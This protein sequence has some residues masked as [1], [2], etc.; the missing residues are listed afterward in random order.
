MSRTRH[1]FD[2]FRIIAP[3]VL[4]MS[5]V[6][7]LIAPDKSH[8]VKSLGLALMMTAMSIYLFRLKGLPVAQRPPVVFTPL[9]KGLVAVF[10]LGTV[11]C[12]AGLAGWPDS[13]NPSAFDIGF[14]LLLITVPTTLAATLALYLR[15]PAGRARRAA[16]ASA[17]T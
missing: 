17:G 5:V 9:V 8:L 10:C 13:P 3:L 15:S 4:A 2:P 11:L 6:L 12:G 16:L 14:G 7:A 1:P